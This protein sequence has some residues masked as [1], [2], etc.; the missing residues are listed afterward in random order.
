[1]LNLTIRDLGP[2]V[3]LSVLAPK[4]YLKKLGV[5][6][7]HRMHRMTQ[8]TQN[9]FG[10]IFSSILWFLTKFTTEFSVFC[11]PWLG[12]RSRVPSRISP[13]FRT[14]DP[15]LRVPFFQD[16]RP[17]TQQG[18]RNKAMQIIKGPPDRSWAPIYFLTILSQ[19]TNLTQL[20][21]T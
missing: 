15:C 4:N 9:Y 2:R 19:I 6:K 18:H 16:Q 17:G 5:C 3:L 13:F 14:W 12:L 11:G 21:L 7:N 8:K 1:M 20:N 10:R